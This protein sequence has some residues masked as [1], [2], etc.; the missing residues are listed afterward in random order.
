MGS[1]ALKKARM[2]G[3]PTMRPRGVCSLPCVCVLFLHDA[4]R[5]D[6]MGVDVDTRS[7]DTWSDVHAA[8]HAAA[9][10][11]VALLSRWQIECAWR[12]CIDAR[13][14]HRAHATAMQHEVECTPRTQ[15]LTAVLA[16]GRKRATADA[17]SS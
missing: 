5:A 17:W 3:A 12:P 15:P 14:L 8:V 10:V 7:G 6:K 2:L 13:A 1:T 9:A 16:S 4:H 11:C